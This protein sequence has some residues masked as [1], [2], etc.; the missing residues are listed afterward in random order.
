VN[1]FF[2]IAVPPGTGYSNRFIN[3]GNI[4]NNGV[5]VMATYRTARARGLRW[6]TQVNFDLNRNK[7]KSLAAGVDQ[8]VLLENINNYSNILKKGGSYGDLYGQVLQRDS[9]TG[10]ILINTDGTPAVASA[11]GYVGNANP[12]WKLGWNNGFEWKGFSLNVLVDGTFGGQVM[13][14]TQQVLDGYGVSKASGDARAQGGVKVDGIEVGTGHAV[15]TVDAQKWYTTIGGRQH[16]TGEYMYSATTVR[17]R[18][19]SIGYSLPAKLLGNAGIKRIDLSLVGRN[20]WY[21]HRDAPFDPEMSLS[22]GNQ[23]PGIDISGL[24]ATRSYGLS[25]NLTF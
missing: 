24:P 5:E 23:W 9:A 13:A 2:S 12:R 11:L 1:Q 10:K 22:T 4:Q 21:I 15:T 14:L 3:G 18:Q 19:L 25:L 8:Y 6:N 17:L 20:L 7:V 16:T